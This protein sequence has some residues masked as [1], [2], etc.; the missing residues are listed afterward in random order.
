MITLVVVGLAAL[1]VLALV[2]GLVDAAQAADRRWVARDRRAN[3]E[4]RQ[5]EDRLAVARERFPQP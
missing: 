1:V 2:V 3:W 5:R 4:Q